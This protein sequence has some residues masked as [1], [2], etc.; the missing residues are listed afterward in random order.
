MIKF[1]DLQKLNKSY[2]ADFV[3]V[4]QEF[5]QSG[6]YILGKQVAQFEKNFADYCGTKYCIGVANGLD[7]LILILR[8]Y[9]E[10][11]KLQ[12]GDEVIVPANTYIASILAIIEAGLEPVFVEPDIETFNISIEGIKE[13]I[14]WKTRVIMPVHL[15][16]ELANMNAI[17]TLAKEQNLIVVEDAAQAHGASNNKGIRA[18]NLGYAAGFSFYP[19]KNLGALGDGGA[20]TTNDDKLAAIVMKMRNYGCSSKYVNDVKGVNSRLDEVQAM[21]LNI[22]LK[23][24]DSQNKKRVEIAKKYL[25]NISTHKIKLPQYSGDD[26]HVFHQFVV[27]VE[28][29]DNFINYL[30]ENNVETLIHYPIPPHKQKALSEYNHFS[31]PNTETIHEQVVS[32]PLNPILLDNEVNTIIELLNTY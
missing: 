24:L 4:H 30:K 26:D 7:A 1:L 31:F 12:K 25:D 14:T 13:A 27:R 17:N 8:G 23:D 6:R 22:K 10:I 5:L 18:G 11:G 2:E 19:S 29:R 3:K 28:N 20:I 9:I 32:I 21:Y 16:G 15:Y